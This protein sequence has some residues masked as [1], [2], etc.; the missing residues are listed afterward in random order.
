MNDQGGSCTLAPLLGARSSNREHLV[1][2]LGNPTK[3]T[4]SV[5]RRP[6]RLHPSKSTAF[7]VRSLH[8]GTQQQSCCRWNFIVSRVVRTRCY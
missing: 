7:E 5:L 6:N 4:W 3:A 2:Q 1:A 8:I